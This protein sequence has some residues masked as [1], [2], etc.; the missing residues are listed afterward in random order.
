MPAAT[1][2]STINDR[3]R[4]S[5]GIVIGEALKDAELAAAAR[6]KFFR[7]EGS[8][9]CVNLNHSELTAG[10]FV[11]FSHM[12]AASF[13]KEYKALKNPIKKTKKESNAVQVAKLTENTGKAERK[14][15]KDM[16]A[17][18]LNKITLPNG[19]GKK[20]KLTIAKLPTIA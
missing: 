5:D 16:V 4:Y 8:G 14:K 13:W 11:R 6:P 1:S 3:L 19:H 20:P 15:F 17:K 2:G 9:E 18:L 10:S 12:S 7:F